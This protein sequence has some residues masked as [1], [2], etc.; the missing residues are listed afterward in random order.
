MKI[1][2]RT[3]FKKKNEEIERLQKIIIDVS[4][5][6][7]YNYEQNKEL[8]NKISL[9]EAEKETLENKINLLKAGKEILENKIRQING[10]KGGYIKQINKLNKIHQ[11]TKNSY[12]NSLKTLNNELLETKSKLEES[13]TDKYRVRKIRPATSKQKQTMKIKSGY[14]EGKIINK[15]KEEI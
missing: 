8:K 5:K 15:I 12:E 1:L 11:E 4:S 10:S 13:M 14:I 6:S 3:I 2:E 9:L 7:K